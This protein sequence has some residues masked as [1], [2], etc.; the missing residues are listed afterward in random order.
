MFCSSCG[1]PIPNDD[2]R[3]VYSISR[4]HVAAPFFQGVGQAPH[5]TQY[6]GVDWPLCSLDC[7]RRF[8]AG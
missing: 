4:V 5:H 8:A 6:P 7:L 1:Q 2:E 3:F